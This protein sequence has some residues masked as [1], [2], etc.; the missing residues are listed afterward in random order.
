MRKRTIVIIISF[1]SAFILM[2]GG[3]GFWQKPLI[4]K[5]KIKVIE[6]PKPEISVGVSVNP[7]A[8]DLDIPSIVEPEIPN[9]PE[10]SVGIVPNEQNGVGTDS[11]SESKTEEIEPASIDQDTKI[12]VENSENIVNPD[13]EQAVSETAKGENTEEISMP[14]AEL[15]ET[16]KDKSIGTETEVV[17]E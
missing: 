8:L 13:Q 9:N 4:I 16:S 5:G 6:L 15:D 3:Y 17:N 7:V 2:S 1:I 12:Q 14:K 11:S 10:E